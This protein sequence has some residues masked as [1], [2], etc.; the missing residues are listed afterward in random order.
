M[1]DQISSF[2]SRGLATAF[3]G[4]AQLDRQTQEG[5][6]TGSFQLVYVTPEAFMDNAFYTSML[7]E[8]MEG[9]FSGLHCC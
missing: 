1:K 9:E 2:Q 3:C 6:R 4:S 8:S 5:I 7:L